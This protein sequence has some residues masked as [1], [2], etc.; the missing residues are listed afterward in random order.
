MIDIHHHLVFGVDDGSR[1][2]EM[3]QAMIR[4]AMENHVTAICCSSH[5]T[6]GHRPF[7]W[8][9]Y[10]DHIR[11]LGDWIAQEG[12]ALTLYS[13]CEILYTDAA[14]RM[15]VQSEIP[16]LAG[17]SS[18]LVEFIPNV[19]WD[20][21]CH[22]CRDM[23]NHGLNM[24]IAHVERYQCLHE[25]M[26]RLHEL[27]DS[28]GVYLQMNCNSVLK[29]HGFFGDRFA[30]YAV[31]ERLIDVAASDSHNVSSRACNMLACHDM[32]VRD[33]G[34]DMAYRLTEEQPKKILGI[35]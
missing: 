17:T 9:T 18:V 26:K 23:G 30:K 22:A 20:L 11:Q 31:K 5:C 34:E 29:A 19:E 33:Y 27:H 7:P 15:A 21:I 14:A 28:Y 1:D 35:N 2:F 13:G 10:M 3:S 24:V 8:D 4:K 12:L 25:N 32:L 16:T 6:P